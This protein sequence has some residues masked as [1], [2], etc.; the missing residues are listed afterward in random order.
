[1]YTVWFPLCTS[2]S[3][4]GSVLVVTSSVTS[5]MGIILL[6]N[7]LFWVFIRKSYNLR[8]PDTFSTASST[9]CSFSN[10]PQRSTKLTES[11]PKIEISP[12]PARDSE[13]KALAPAS[14]DWEGCEGHSRLPGTPQR[15]SS[16]QWPE[17][18]LSP[19]SAHPWDCSL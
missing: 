3:P 17:F 4:R 1:M 15:L 14:Q 8:T 5:A 12:A 10:V 19:V 7:I 9:A 18:N 13:I 11:Q 6:V 2:L 16:L